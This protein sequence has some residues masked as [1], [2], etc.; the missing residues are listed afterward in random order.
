MHQRY[1]PVWERAEDPTLAEDFLPADAQT[2]HKI[3]RNLLMFD[4]IAGPAIEYWRDMAFS[5]NVILSGI[6]DEKVL[7]FYQDAITSSGII[8]QMPM[9]LS[10]YL[11]FG[12]FVFHMLM[13]ENNLCI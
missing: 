5:Q 3:F 11:A 4:A 7:Q 10:D 8:T 2:Q 9:L 13:D 1:S 12:K 6:D